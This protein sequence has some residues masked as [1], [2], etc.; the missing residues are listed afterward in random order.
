M[1]IEYKNTNKLYFKLEFIYYN[2]Y[3]LLNIL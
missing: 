1:Q 3:Y 2:I